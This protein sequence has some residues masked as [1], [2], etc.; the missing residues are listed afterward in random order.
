MLAIVCRETIAQMFH[1]KQKKGAQSEVDQRVGRSSKGP[2]VKAIRRPYRCHCVGVVLAHDPIS[3][4]L[5]SIPKA[6]AL[7]P[8]RRTHLRGAAW[9]ISPLRF[10]L[11]GRAKSVLKSSLF[12]SQAEPELSRRGNDVRQTA[13][14][15]WSSAGDGSLGR[16]FSR[17]P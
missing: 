16:F 4:R 14:C 8:E 11:F 1:D 5:D 17:K 12:R 9:S 7:E 3:G 13:R 6:S 2:S 10:A 15:Q